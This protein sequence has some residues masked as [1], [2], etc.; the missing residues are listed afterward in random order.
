M[1]QELITISS[2][3]EIHSLTNKI[4]KEGKSIGFVPT[5]GFLHD[6]HISLI[7]EA[8]KNNDVTIVSIFV[9][10]TQF[11]PTEDLASYPRDLEKDKSLLINAEVDYLFFPN[12]EDFYPN[13][14]QTF[15]EVNKISKILEGEFRPT[16]FKGVTT[17]VAMLFNCINPDNAYF[18][19]KDAQQAAVINQMVK[20]LKYD[21]KINVSPI[22]RENDGLAMSSRNVYLN[23]KERKDALVL[24]RSLSIADELIKN[25]EK[26]TTN[27]LNEMKK[28]INSVESSDL[29]YVSIVEADSFTIIDTIEKGRSYYI[30]VACKIGKTRLIDNKF[31]SI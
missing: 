20:D 4:R 14:F 26:N 22:V 19:Q 6:G 29:N 1:H 2:I 16:H 24:S 12:T 13:D 15:V 8:K 17:V 21:I 28:K 23:E 7:K 18:G 25:G 11:S 30:L 5:M 10:P 9:N 31:V 27:I 3:D